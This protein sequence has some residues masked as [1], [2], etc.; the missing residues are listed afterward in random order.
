MTQAVGKQ[1]GCALFLYR[2][3]VSSFEWVTDV[4]LKKKRRALLVF[5]SGKKFLAPHRKCGSSGGG[6]LLIKDHADSWFFAGQTSQEHIIVLLVEL[7]NNSIVIYFYLGSRADSSQ[8]S[9]DSG[10]AC[11]CNKLEIWARACS[12]MLRVKLEQAQIEPSSEWLGLFAALV[13]TKEIFWKG[14]EWHRSSFPRGRVG[15]VREH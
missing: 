4:G 11:L 3:L 6:P 9:I 14:M 15:N 2:E 12:F 13:S 1:E 10:S 7:E 5:H 8:A